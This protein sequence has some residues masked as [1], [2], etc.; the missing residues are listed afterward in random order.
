[1]SWVKNGFLFNNWT[2]YIT[3]WP[4]IF[5]PYEGELIEVIESPTFKALKG[6]TWIS[7]IFPAFSSGAFEEPLQ[8]RG[9]FIRRGTHENIEELSGNFITKPQF[10][11]WEIRI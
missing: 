2:H 3:L 11:L 8:L 9:D 10:P 1:M 5:I 7:H 4:H 6:V